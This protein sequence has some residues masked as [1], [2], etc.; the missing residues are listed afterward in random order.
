MEH[1]KFVTI[2]YFTLHN[3]STQAQFAFLL[4]IMEVPGVILV[5][6]LSI[7]NKTFYDFTS[8]P[9]NIWCNILITTPTLSSLDVHNS[10]SQT[11]LVQNQNLLPKQRR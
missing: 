3:V 8:L 5:S 9:R 7:L 4:T 10:Q 1:I 2:S 6:A 11:H